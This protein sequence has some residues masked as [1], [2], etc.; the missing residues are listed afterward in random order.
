LWGTLNDR[1]S[2]GG[3]ISIGPSEP[4]GPGSHYFASF[5]IYIVFLRS[6]LQLLDAANVVPSSLI[7]STLMMD[8]IRSS[9]MSVLTRGT[10]HHIPED[11]ILHSH[12]REYLSAT[13]KGCILQR[14]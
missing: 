7:L 11:G 3:G 10:R 2:K 14:G 4:S 5:I 9:D 8:A 1:T 12:C 6:V 13:D